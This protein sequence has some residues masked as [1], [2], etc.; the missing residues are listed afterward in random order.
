M[1][2]SISS[3]APPVHAAASPNATAAATD[4]APIAPAAANTPKKHAMPLPD[5]Q[6]QL[7]LEGSH[8]DATTA[9]REWLKAQ[10][11]THWTEEPE[12]DEHR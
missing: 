9:F 4:T 11:P 10:P 3:N 8:H 7:D 6:L 2:R 5:T 12:D 1:T